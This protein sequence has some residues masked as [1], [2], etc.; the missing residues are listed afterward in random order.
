MKR[1][2]TDDG[3]LPAH[4]TRLGNIRIWG[5][6]NSSTNVPNTPSSNSNHT[7]TKPRAFP[8]GHINKKKPKG[9]AA[10]GWQRQAMQRAHSSHDIVGSDGSIT[11]V[12]TPVSSPRT[13]SGRDSGNFSFGPT[14]TAV[15]AAKASYDLQQQQYDDGIPRTSSTPSRS[16]SN[17][18]SPRSDDSSSSP[19]STQQRS[20]SYNATNTT[21]TTATHKVPTTASTTSTT[22]TASTASTATTATD[23]T[24]TATLM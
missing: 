17:R 8:L 16:V 12:I 2:G 9:S 18:S 1:E 22:S 20:R 11:P 23:A 4:V 7:T 3:R 6:K 14:E 15:T 10:S 19:R 21:N 24:T 13:A 5:R